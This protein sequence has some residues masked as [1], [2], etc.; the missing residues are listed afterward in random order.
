MPDGLFFSPAFAKHLQQPPP[1]FLYHYTSQDGLLGIIQSRA[2]WATNI[3]YTNDATEFELSLGLLKDRLFNEMGIGLA[4]ADTARSTRH[5]H[6]KSRAEM[7]WKRVNMITGP[8]ICI[9][10]FCKKDDLLSQWRGYSGGG[11]AYSL[12]FKTSELQKI[13]SR[14][15]FLLGKCIYDTDL[16]TQI[17]EEIVQHLLGNG[18]SAKPPRIKDFEPLL[19]HGAFFKDPSFEEEQEWRLVSAFP[20]DLRFR[21]GKSMIIPYTSLDISAGENL[22]IRHARV[23]PC[24]HMTLSTQSAQIMLAH[25]NI[26]VLVDRSAIPF[27]DW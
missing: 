26:N 17:I 23:G 25:N 27:R 20:A 16:Q 8:N 15:G 18:P 6:I 2:L 11:Y 10:C 24:P 22:C 1:E 12:G 14:A 7:L 13:A 5:N 4:A 21:K 19:T 3:S 9:T